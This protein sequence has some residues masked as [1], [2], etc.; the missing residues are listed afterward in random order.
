MNRSTA[1]KYAAYCLVFALVIFPWSLRNYLVLGEI[2]PVATTGSVVLQGSAER[3][4][5]VSG[6]V[7]EYPGYF[8]LLKARGIEAPPRPTAVEEDRFLYRAGL[9]SYK[10]LLETNPLGIVP[11]M[12]KK[13]VRLWYATESGRG[14]LKVLAVNLPI[15]VLAVLGTVLALRRRVTLAWMIY[16]V[17]GYFILLH[18]LSFPLFRYVLPVMP[19]LIVFAAFA[20]DSIW[21]RSE[22]VA[23]R[24]LR[25]SAAG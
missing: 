20:L 24:S 2:I 16:L 1:L 6:K 14:Y 3:F 18:W 15:Y 13:F 9:E 4:W 12:A 21:H 11:L 19:Y 7:K 23:V 25:S 22:D 8:E 5:T 17:L 10:I